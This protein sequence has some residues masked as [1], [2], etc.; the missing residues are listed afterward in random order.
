MKKFLS[1]IFIVALS[2][3]VMAGCTNDNSNESDQSQKE[4]PQQQQESIEINV[5]APQGAPTL[6]MI[7]M[8]KEKPSLGENIEVNYESVES[9]DVIASKLTSN[10]VDI[11][12][13]PTNLA[14][15]LYNKDVK[16]KLVGANVWGI[17]YLASDKELNSIND[18]K[19]ETIST[20]GRGL[21][22]DVVFR[23]ILSKNDI[24]PEKDLEIKYYN[25]GT[26]L[27]S[28]LIAGKDS[29][30]VVPEPMLSKVLLKNNNIKVNLNIQDEWSKATGLEGGYPQ[31]CLVVSEK[32][33]EENPKAVEA[34]INEF[35]KSIDWVN[36][37]PTQAGDYSEELE[38][39]IDAKM[40]ETGIERSNLK[41]VN[42][43]D[44]KE[45]I[46]NYFNI[47]FEYSPKLVGGKLPDEDFYYTK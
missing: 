28:S 38:T 40:L 34:F 44:S 24:D 15:T 12:I 3:G 37:N 22:P 13:I 4:Q 20:I 19:G 14:A 39:G 26:E 27:A 33:I 46:E 43:K 10:E 9:P 42:A 6:S 7:K 30:A 25:G 47:L 23:Y 2:L 36:Q 29:V 21:T 45:S 31:A 1:L 41:F 35:E 16:Y 17:L 18:L 32:L 5:V 11:A 8:M